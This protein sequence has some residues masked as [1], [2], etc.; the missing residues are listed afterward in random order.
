MTT[1]QQTTGDNAVIAASIGK[2][3]LPLL[4]PILVGIGSAAI[5]T[6]ITMTQLEQ[7]VT[8]LERSFTGHAKDTEG[9]RARDTE[10]ER[11]ISR[12]ESLSE[13]TQRNLDEI[14]T[15][16]KTLLKMERAKP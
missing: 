4:I 1:T 10:Y 15:D 9:F 8:H 12:V 11:R 6:T 7:R 3:I 2:H 5:T 16:I 14:R 13:V